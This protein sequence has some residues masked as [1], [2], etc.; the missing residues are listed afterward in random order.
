MTTRLPATSRIES[1]SRWLGDPQPAGRPIHNMRPGGGGAC[2]EPETFIPGG[3]QPIRDFGD[4]ECQALPV[5]LGERDVDRL[6]R[7]IASGR[8]QFRREVGWGRA[9]ASG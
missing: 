4:L 3:S 6:G 5:E 2:A 9:R 7:R 8:P 1:V